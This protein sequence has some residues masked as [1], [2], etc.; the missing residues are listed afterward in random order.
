[1]KLSFINESIF[2][3]HKNSFEKGNSG[4]L[5]LFLLYIYIY[6]KYAPHNL[7]NKKQKQQLLVYISKD[8]NM[9]IRALALENANAIFKGNLAFAALKSSASE[10]CKGKYC[11]FF[12]NTVTV[13]L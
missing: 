6:I 5:F 12:C 11:K 7:L 3:P 1:M 9:Y 8:T 4:F 10:N 13:Q 2:E